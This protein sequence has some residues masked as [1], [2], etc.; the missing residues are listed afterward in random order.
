MRSILSSSGRSLVATTVRSTVLARARRWSWK[1][2]IGS[3][4]TS[5]NTLPG[6]LVE[7]MR[8]CTIARAPTPWKLR[9]RDLHGRRFR[10]GE[11]LEVGVDH[12]LDEV[13]E[14][15]ARLPAKVALSLRRVPDELV[16]LSRAEKLRVRLHGALRVQ[17]HMAEGDL[18][19]LAHRM[20]LAS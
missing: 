14:R 19:E 1:A 10:P 4:P 5:I 6:S 15:V 7:D 3:P 13:A 20:R 9:R 8:A 12:H 16:D 2:S 18:R 11:P 17:A